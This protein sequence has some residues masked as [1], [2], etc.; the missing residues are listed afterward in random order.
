MEELQGVTLLVNILVKSNQIFSKCIKFSSDQKS[1]VS[2]LLTTKI[3]IS[4]PPLFKIW[5]RKLSDQQ[6]GETDIA[7]HKLYCQ[8]SWPAIVRLFYKM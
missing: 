6:I 3:K 2:F 1:L 8:S 4:D 7:G 5:G